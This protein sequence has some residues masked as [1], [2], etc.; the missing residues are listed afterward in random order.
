MLSLDDHA[1]EDRK[2]NQDVICMS[3]LVLIHVFTGDVADVFACQSM[4]AVKS[5]C[6]CPFLARSCLDDLV[7]RE[8]FGCFDCLSFL[9]VFWTF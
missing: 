3:S 1:G 2:R 4:L 6:F 5:L 9:N 7:L 8:Q